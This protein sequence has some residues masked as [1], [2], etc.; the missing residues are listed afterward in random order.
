MILRA[1]RYSIIVI[2]SD[3][4]AWWTMKAFMLDNAIHDAWWPLVYVR[5]TTC[6]G[7]PVYKEQEA[8][9]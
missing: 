3:G 5:L 6:W 2:S 9:K 4:R 1:A 8:R 7:M